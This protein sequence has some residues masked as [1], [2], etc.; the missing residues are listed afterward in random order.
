MKSSEHNLE[1]TRRYLD[2]DATPEEVAELEKRMLADPQLK[3]DFLRYARIDASLPGVVNDSGTLL[4]YEPVKK[5]SQKGWA[6]AAVIALSFLLLAQVLNQ[7]WGDKNRQEVARFGKIENCRWT[8]QEKTLLSG[9]PVTEGQRIEIS[10]GK[11]ELLYHNGARIELTGPCIIETISEKETFLT[12]G[13]VYVVADS[14][15]SQGFMVRSPT[16][17]FEDLGTAFS[18]SVAPDGLSRLEVSDGEVNLIV[19]QD[20]KHQLLQAGQT[21]LVEPGERKILTR[22]ESGDESRDFRFPTIVPPSN[23]DYADIS[24]GFASASVGRGLLRSR[25]D[26]TVNPKSILDGSGQTNQDSPQESVFFENDVKNGSL[27]IDLGKAISIAK[28]NSYSW[29]QHNRIPEH[30]DRAQQKFTLFGW[31][32]K[33]LPNLEIPARESGWVRIARVN[34]EQFFHVKQ[35]DNR[36]SQQACS[37]FASKGEIGEYRYLLLEVSGPTFFGEID[38]YQSE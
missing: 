34:S 19:E 36:P 24:Q 10:S 29:H 21:M 7:P 28:I 2:G 27:L 20:H 12:M 9:D 3:K 35:L 33:Q 15:E 1:L 31:P 11:V 16:S 23:Q 30:N 38:V 17:I 8:N 22:I 4:D 14:P 18:A 13:T 37:I 5:K 6:I 25:P 32:D 26:W